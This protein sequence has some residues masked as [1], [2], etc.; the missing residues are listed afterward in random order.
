MDSQPET[1]EGDT[2]ECIVTTDANDTES[3]SH[4]MVTVYWDVNSPTKKTDTASTTTLKQFRWAK[5]W[6]MRDKQLAPFSEMETEA[7]VISFKLEHPAHFKDHQ[8]HYK[9]NN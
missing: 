7:K 9:N 5:T 6:E 2:N 3:V 4:K 8:G 1:L